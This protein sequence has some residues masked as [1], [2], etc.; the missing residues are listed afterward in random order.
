[1]HIMMHKHTLANT[2]EYCLNTIDNWIDNWKIGK[3]KL[4]SQRITLTHPTLELGPRFPKFECTY[5]R[6][7]HTNHY[8]Q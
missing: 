2:R 8:V 1:M 7:G 5:G 6:G 4:T 3:K